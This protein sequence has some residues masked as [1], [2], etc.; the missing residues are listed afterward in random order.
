MQVVN[1]KLNSRKQYKL[2]MYHN[3]CIHNYNNISQLACASL[4]ANETLLYQNESLEVNV[5]TDQFNFC[6]C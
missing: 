5:C 3:T 1:E 6:E 4:L 2:F